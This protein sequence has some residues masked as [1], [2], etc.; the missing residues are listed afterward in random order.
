MKTVLFF[1]DGIYNLP[2]KCHHRK[3]GKIVWQLNN[4]WYS[5]FIEIENLPSPK[6]KK[7]WKYLHQNKWTLPLPII[8][9]DK[10]KTFFLF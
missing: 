4:Q 5:K 9:R 3:T 8:I 1:Y 2:E 7:F 6:K 10:T